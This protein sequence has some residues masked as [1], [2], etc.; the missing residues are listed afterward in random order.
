MNIPWWYSIVRDWRFRMWLETDHWPLATTNSQR[1]Q[2]VVVDTSSEQ[3][4]DANLPNA[5]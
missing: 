4:P 2:A 5:A 1:G 3:T